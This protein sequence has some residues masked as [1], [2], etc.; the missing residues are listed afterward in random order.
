MRELGPGGPGRAAVT[1]RV[2]CGPVQP[3]SLQPGP[4]QPSA[5]TD[6]D[7]GVLDGELPVALAQ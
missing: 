4:A 1:I 7:G 2:R 6:G 3:G 5:G